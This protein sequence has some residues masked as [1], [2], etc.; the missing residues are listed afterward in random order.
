MFQICGANP[1]TRASIAACLAIQPGLRS[2]RPFKRKFP[3]VGQNNFF[4]PH[5]IR[6]VARGMSG[7]R[8]HV[9]GLDGLPVPAFPDEHVRARAFSNPSF[10]LAFAVPHFQKEL[11]VGIRKLE[12][13]NGSHDGKD[14]R[15]VVTCAP[16]VRE[17][18]MRHPQE[19]SPGN[20]TS[21]DSLLHRS[22]L[23]QASPR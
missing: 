16:M 14:L 4:D 3:A 20:Q 12:G 21:R 13:G 9:S 2:A 18:G 6:A 10:D 7:R 17:R 19:C 22:P 11:R 1:A 8:N 15:W 23:E 5:V